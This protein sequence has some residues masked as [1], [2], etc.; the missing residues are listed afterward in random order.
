MAQ[1][2]N[3]ISPSMRVPSLLLSKIGD[4]TV[5]ALVTALS[6]TH[7]YSSS[8]SR[9]DWAWFD[10]LDWDKSSDEASAFTRKTCSCGN[11]AILMWP[12]NSTVAPFSASIELMSWSNTTPYATF[13]IYLSAGDY[14]AFN[15]SSDYIITYGDY[16]SCAIC[17]RNFLFFADMND[18]I[19]GFAGRGEVQGM[20]WV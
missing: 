4:N 9:P 16:T 11:Y 2:A 13:N 15:E 8:T 6:V 7:Y 17:Q 1:K 18:K 20:R 14:A 10:C 12:E 5:Q 19:P 3:N